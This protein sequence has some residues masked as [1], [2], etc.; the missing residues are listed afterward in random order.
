[1]QL[2]KVKYDYTWTINVAT[3]WRGKFNFMG[4]KCT[5]KNKNLLL[6]RYFQARSAIFLGNIK[7]IVHGLLRKL[8]DI[9]IGN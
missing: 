2:I 5:D 3:Y 4:Y 9:I 7:N 1:M 8:K 6:F